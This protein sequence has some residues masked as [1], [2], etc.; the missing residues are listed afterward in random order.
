MFFESTELSQKKLAMIS[1]VLYFNTVS[2]NDSQ[3]E[4]DLARC[5]ARC[6]VRFKK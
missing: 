4:S 5:K 1:L 2:N 6:R 3:G